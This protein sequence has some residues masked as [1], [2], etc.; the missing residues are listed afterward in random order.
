M[1]ELPEVE[2][3]RR[4]LAPTLVGARIA[5]VELRRPD[6][7]FPFPPDFAK[8]LQGR[9][10]LG[11]ERR[12]KYLIASLDDGAA[13]IAHLGMSGSFRIEGQGEPP[14][15]F[16]LPRSKNP[17]H[18]HVVIHLGEASVVYNDPRRFGFM[19]LAAAG[20]L[21][22]HPFFAELGV[23]PLSN[24][25]NA[26][27]L[28]QLFAGRKTSLK[29]ALLDQK[30][31]AGL[32]NIYVC[33]ALH[34]A[35]LAPDRPA[36][37]VVG[38]AGAPGKAAERLARSI[39]DVLEEAVLAGGSSLRDHR[40]A[41]GSLGYFQHNFRV[42]NRVGEACPTPACR[43]IIERRVQNGRSTFFCPKCQK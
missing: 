27:T 28:A 14:G 41:D 3:V 22:S 31:I 34:R 33:E 6:L 1:P 29:A 4:G 8:L 32:G 35:G 23:E 21:E 15:A 43:G 30:L 26:E 11:L 39:R 9:R 5:R 24:S 40:Q 19:T 20:T 25:F 2:T 17:A 42:Y 36:G 10:I 37:D 7:R 38:K 18:D 13:L 12:A 16:A